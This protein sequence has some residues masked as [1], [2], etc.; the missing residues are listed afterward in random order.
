MTVEKVSNLIQLELTTLFIRKGEDC[1][2]LLMGYTGCSIICYLMD[3]LQ[4]CIQYSQISVKDANGHAEL[5]MLLATLVYFSLD[6][7]YFMWVL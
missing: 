4:L 2:K 6:F 5:L 7:Y 1:K 3:G